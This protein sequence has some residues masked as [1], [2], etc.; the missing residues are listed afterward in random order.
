MNTKRCL[1]I[2]GLDKSTEGLCLLFLSL[3]QGGGNCLCSSN[4]KVENARL[5]PCAA[6]T[7][8]SSDS[9]IYLDGYDK[10]VFIGVYGQCT[11]V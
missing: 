1:N 6:H 4:T 2:F 3:A 8:D 11:V 7:W 9:Q 10:D 5:F